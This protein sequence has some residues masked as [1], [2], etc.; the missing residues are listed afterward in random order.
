MTGAQE[1]GPNA[2][3]ATG[4]VTVS[5]VG[6]VLSVDLSFSGLT[7]GSATAAHIHCCIAPGT[8]VGVAIGFPGFP[9][10]TS[11]TYMHDFDLLNAATYTSTFLTDFGAGSAA[12]AEAALLAG[13]D[14]GQAYANIH[15]STF[16][17]GEIR[18][19]LVPEPSTFSLIG[20]ALVGIAAARL[21]RR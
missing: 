18:G 10:A 11:G 9:A 3:T 5:V 15:D 13:L 19:N 7:G 12:G 6:D 16:P 8:N 2:S 1:I 4:S 14:A 17:G 20:T 21:R